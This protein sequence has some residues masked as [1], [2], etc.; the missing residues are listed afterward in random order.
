MLGKLIRILS[1]KRATD[2]AAVTQ[3]VVE[4]ELP[5]AEPAPSTP[6]LPF[7]IRPVELQDLPHLKA[8][9]Q[10]AIEALTAQDYSDDQR[11]AWQ[12]DA[13]EDSFADALQ[14]GVT[15]VAD[16]DGTPVAFAQLH[17]QNHV[18]MLYVDPEWSGLGIPM[19][20]YQYLEDEARILGSK[21]LSTHASLT[22]LKFFKSMGFNDDGEEQVERRGTT[23]PR[24]AM[25]K[26]LVK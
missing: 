18:R 6:G 14:Q 3:P 5:A 22:A 1:G 7:M 19:L 2:K 23:L 26:M 17:P 15:I 12:A 13:Q 11:Q 24:H 8:V 16:N 9:F 4:A 25:S 20:L 21:T 10:R